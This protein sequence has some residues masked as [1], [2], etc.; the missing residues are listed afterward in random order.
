[1]QVSNTAS[2][3]QQETPMDLSIWMTFV[4]ASVALIVIPGPT[5]VLVLTYALTQGRWVAVAL[6]LVI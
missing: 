5:V 4:A 3:G 6:A 1:M 2:G